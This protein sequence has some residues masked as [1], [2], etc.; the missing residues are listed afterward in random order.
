VVEQI[1]TLVKSMRVSVLI[2]G[3][4][5]QKILLSMACPVSASDCRNLI[6]MQALARAPVGVSQRLG[7]K[8]N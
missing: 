5:A 3:R 6:D 4:F 2:V 7:E 1:E 8:L